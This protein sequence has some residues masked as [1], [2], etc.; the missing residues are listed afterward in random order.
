MHRLDHFFHTY[1]KKIDLFF[2]GGKIKAIH[3][4]PNN[5]FKYFK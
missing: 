5:R 4:T 3:E 1:E 2:I